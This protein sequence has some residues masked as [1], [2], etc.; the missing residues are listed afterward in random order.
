[1]RGACLVFHFGAY[2]G[3]RRMRH[4]ADAEGRPAP[5][6]NIL[7]ALRVELS[8]EA[9]RYKLRLCRARQLGTERRM[10]TLGTRSGEFVRGD[11][12]P[13]GHARVQTGTTGAAAPRG[14]GPRAEVSCRRLAADGDDITGR[15]VRIRQPLAHSVV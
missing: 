11:V 2:V 4:R 12:R 3:G 7:H 10:A 13:A 8:A 6:G 9:H 15:L 14:V 1:D 5:S